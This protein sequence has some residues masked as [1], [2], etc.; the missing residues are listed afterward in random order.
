MSDAKVGGFVGV[1]ITADGVAVGETVVV[2]IVAEGDATIF[3]M[4]LCFGVN[5]AVSD[6]SSAISLSITDSIPYFH[7]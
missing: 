7:L 1:F 6:N 3:G 4:F 2:I 5:R